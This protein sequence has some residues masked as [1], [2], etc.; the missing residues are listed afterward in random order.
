M[1]DLISIEDARKACKIT[2]AHAWWMVTTGRWNAVHVGPG[3]RIIRVRDFEVQDT[4][5]KW[6]NADRLRKKEI[7]ESSRGARHYVEAKASA[8]A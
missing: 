7:R 2:F 4:I 3:Y 6:A 1:S 5:N 8:T